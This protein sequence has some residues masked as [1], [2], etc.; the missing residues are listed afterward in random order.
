MHGKV[1]QKIEGIYEFES[2]FPS[3]LFL[4]SKYFVVVR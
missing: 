1:D 3:Y 4:A 2:S